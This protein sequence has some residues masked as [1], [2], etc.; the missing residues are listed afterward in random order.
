MA[1]YLILKLLMKGANSKYTYSD[2]VNL[3]KD[4]EGSHSDLWPETTTKTMWG[5][6]KLSHITGNMIEEP[7]LL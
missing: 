6:S 5:N 7:K 2:F 1:L 4:N 3:K